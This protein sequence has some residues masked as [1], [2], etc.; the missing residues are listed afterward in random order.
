MDT[1]KCICEEMGY[2]IRILRSE[3]YERG[4][5][6][7]KAIL[8]RATLICGTLSNKNG[9]TCQYKC[10]LRGYIREEE[11]CIERTESSTS[12]TRIS[13]VGVSH[14][15]LRIVVLPSACPHDHVSSTSILRKELGSEIVSYARRLQSEG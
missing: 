12:N 5:R 8:R 7:K 15:S 14:Y 4:K 13:E 9:G 10:Q 6:Y 2:P 3:Y 11:V 1:V